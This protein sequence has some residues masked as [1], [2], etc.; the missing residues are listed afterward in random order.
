MNKLL[1]ISILFLLAISCNKEKDTYVCG[2][3]TFSFFDENGNDLF[4]QNIPGHLDTLVLKAYRLSGE[5]IPVY[6][7]NINGVYQFDI[8]ING[9]DFTTI[10]QIGEIATDTLTADY[11]EQGN[12]LFLHHVYYNGQLVMTYEQTTE[13][14]SGKVANIVVKPY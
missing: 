6:Y 13:C 10:L 2:A 11:K 7:G 9:V 4:D 14:G 1:L 5:E 8:G 12:S 3:Q